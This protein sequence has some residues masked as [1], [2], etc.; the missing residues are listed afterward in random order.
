M[1]VCLYSSVQSVSH[2]HFCP[3]PSASQ[4][5]KK[6]EEAILYCK[7]VLSVKHLKIMCKAARSKVNLPGIG[8]GPIESLHAKQNAYFP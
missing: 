8:T 4:S 5:T 6:G 3:D 7:Y 2:S 1:C